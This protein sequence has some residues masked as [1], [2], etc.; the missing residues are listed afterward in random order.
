M[1]RVKAKTCPVPIASG[2]RKGQPCG[3]KAKIGNVTCMRH[4]AAAACVPL[5]DS[6]SPISDLPQHVLEIICSAVAQQSDASE[7]YHSLLA[8][9][10]TSVGFKAA[11]DG[12]LEQLAER[13]ADGIAAAQA[14]CADTLPLPA[15]RQCMDLHLGRKCMGCG[16]RSRDTKVHWPFPARL[17]KDCFG[18]RFVDAWT[19]EQ[20]SGVRPSMFRSMVRS[21]N[22][23]FCRRDVEAIIDC[24]LER[25]HVVHDM[26]CALSY[27]Y[28]DAQDRVARKLLPHAKFIDDAR[29]ELYLASPT[30]RFASN[31]NYDDYQCYEDAVKTELFID[32]LRDATVKADPDI[33]VAAGIPACEVQRASQIAAKT[34][35]ADIMRLLQSNPTDDVASWQDKILRELVLPEVLKQVVRDREDRFRQGVLAQ[36][37]ND[38]AYKFVA[39]QFAC[40]TL[41]CDPKHV[42][43]TVGAVVMQRLRDEHALGRQVETLHIHA[44]ISRVWNLEPWVRQALLRHELEAN[45]TREIRD[46]LA[47]ET[48]DSIYGAEPFHFRRQDIASL[49]L[50]QIDP[51]SGAG[52]LLGQG[53]YT[54]PDHGPPH[55]MA[56]LARRAVRKPL[57][58]YINLLIDSACATPEHDEANREIVRR[59]VALE[60]QLASKKWEWTR[61]QRAWASVVLHTR[62]IQAICPACGYVTSNLRAHGSRTH[63][64]WMTGLQRKLIAHSRAE[65]QG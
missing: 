2:T 60:T 39:S 40:G 50:R 53:E 12:A 26:R 63:G 59:W 7:A 45:V 62:T 9:R 24:T 48:P 49:P 3:A 18:D 31:N 33:Y 23:K 6:Q 41:L 20:M 43:G 44:A 56:Q 51:G 11:A 29:A 57:D 58:G 21:R 14:L 37:V 8:L 10:L 46:R 35:L 5:P 22:N 27:T 32:R 52:V 15:P 42:Y 25:Y 34:S 30:W 1:P 16:C 55:D 13:E 36:R 65:T 17:C 28:T 54:V 19:L 61:V 64:L 38:L 47:Y 4:T